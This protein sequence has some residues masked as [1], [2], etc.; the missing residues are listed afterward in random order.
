LT[1]FSSV[2]RP[3]PEAVE[4]SMR[5]GLADMVISIDNDSCLVETQI[6]NDPRMG[7]RKEVP[8]RGAQR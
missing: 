1:A 3:S 7:V 5:R 4:T 2:S 6:H 8:V